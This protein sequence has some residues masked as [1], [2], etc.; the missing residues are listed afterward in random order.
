MDSK[1]IEPE[2]NFRDILYVILKKVWIMFLVGIVFGGALFT[3]NILQKK[4]T[5]DIFDITRKLSSRES[6][7]QYTV[8]VQNIERARSYS[9]MIENTN[10]QIEDE[11]EYIADSIYMQID[12]ECLYQS[13]AQI[14]LTL[15]NYDSDGIEYSLFSAYERDLR[16]GIYLNSYAESIGSKTDYI[17]EL[18]GFTT[19]A[20]GAAVVSL[21]SDF[22][23]V[24]SMYLSVVGPS[25]DFVNDVM[26]LMISEIQSV[27]N[28]LNHTV[29]AH[30]INLVA[31]QNTIRRD[32][33]VRDYQFGHI[34]K[35]Q[36]LQG[37]ISTYY[38]S[39]DVIA[40]DL[41]VSD[42]KFLLQY[43]N[44]HPEITFE[45]VPT[46]VSEKQVSVSSMVKP[47]LKFIGIGFGA[48]AFI[49]AFIIALIYVFG[50]RF[51]TQAKFFSIF[52]IIN[53]I[54]VLKPLGKQSK[55]IRFINIKTEDDTKLSSENNLKLINANYKNLTKDLSNILITGTGD[56]KA[57]SEAVKALRLKGDFRPDLFNN[58]DVLDDVSK[59]DGVVLLEQRKC[60]LIRTVKNEVHLI[61][62]A[63]TK[64]VGA[65]II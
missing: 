53:K 11:R 12:P 33:S 29:C 26:N 25:E 16:A 23:R 10:S 60:S 46:E 55:Y 61:S 17:K 35:I 64:I 3:Y 50:K 22:D 15:N 58:P 48:G 39:L 40:K 37:T 36:S 57:M 14:N 20:P 5:S 28:E 19:S 32:D 7:V 59:Y 65:I 42:G 44:T 52:P 31:V 47:N 54:G 62:N 9:A 1:N 21:D 34:S 38:Q 45:G 6:D 13:T 18:I 51:S 27:H 8:R 30:T 63:G 24:G 49:V 56:A 43:V 4:Y 41:G 2:I